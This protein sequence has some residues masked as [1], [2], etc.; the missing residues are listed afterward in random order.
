MKKII[1]LTFLFLGSLNMAFSQCTPSTVKG[2]HI[3]QANENLYRIA[4][5]YGVEMADICKWNSIK[6]NDLL[7]L[8]QIL[9]V[10]DLGSANAIPRGYEQEDEFT[11]RGEELAQ[12]VPSTPQPTIP[13]VPGTRIYQMQ[14]GKRHTVRKGENVAGLAD[15]YGFSEK[16]FRNLN[17]L[18]QTKEVT[19]G[20]ILLTSDCACEVI[21]KDTYYGNIYPNTSG[22]NTNSHIGS[23]S[24]P[25]IVNPN[26]NLSSRSDLV[27]Y[28]KREEYKMIEEINLVRSNPSAY[29]KYVE[30]YRKD[31]KRAGYNVPDATVNELVRELRS[32]PKLSTLEPTECLYNAAS[33]H[34]QDIRARGKSGHQGSDGSWPWDRVKNSCPSFQD[35]NENLVEGSAVVREAV[36]ILL[37]DNAVSSRGHRKTLLNPHWTHVACYKIGQVGNRSNNWVQKFGQAKSSTTSYSNHTNMLNT[38]KPSIQKPNIVNHSNTSIN[39]KPTRFVGNA[40]YMNSQENEMVQEV[41]LLRSNPTGYIKYIEAYKKQRNIYMDKD[42]DGLIA[43]LKKTPTLTILQPS[44]CVYNAAYKHGQDVKKMGKSG[45][46]GSDGSWPWDRVKRSCTSFQDG[47]ENLLGG[48]DNVREAV[49]TLL[50]G[51]GVA[52]K[53]HRRTLLNP[54]WT[55]MATYKIGQVGNVKNSWIQQFGQE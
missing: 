17:A 39:S 29:A 11:S 49:I 41:N 6:V 50:I 52:S 42:I 21:N 45:H 2:I 15:L 54:H 44:Q 9:K 34:G 43:E 16:K 36:I 8:C 25:S 3:V 28:M 7:P 30:Q 51:R 33:K 22:H 47:N 14:D 37:I 31:K 46:K 18:G 19:P 10:S 32:T 27:P 24:T 26:K 23:V 5:A 12:P 1:V 35:G 53:E 38:T 55:H 20:S 40:T 48:S 13:T 4:K